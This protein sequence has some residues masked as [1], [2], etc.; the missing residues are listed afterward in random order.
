MKIE[1]ISDPHFDY[2]FKTMD[3]KDFLE[4]YDQV[5]SK[6]ADVIIV[7]GDLGYKNSIN[8]WAMKLIKK[9]YTK[10]LLYT[11]GNNDYRIHPDEVNIYKTSYDRVNEVKTTLE[12]DD[13]ICLDGTMVEIEGVRIAGAMGWYDGTYARKHFPLK[14]KHEYEN[15]LEESWKNEHLDFLHGKGLP[16]FHEIWEKEKLKIE[17]VFMSCDVF[18][19][20]MSPSINKEHVSKEFRHKLSTSYYVFNGEPF[21]KKGKMKY[22]VYGHTHIDYE[23]EVHNTKVVSC[24]IGRKLNKMKKAG[25]IFF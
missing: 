10:K 19:S 13:I 11:F 18:V 25:V 6:E 20:H 4:V 17:K 7:A 23:F 16:S 3:E 8:I 21:M 1:Y 15:C 5:F 24:Q 9:H 2:W 14:L 22:W 12:I